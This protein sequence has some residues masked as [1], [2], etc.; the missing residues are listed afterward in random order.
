MD[1][2]MVLAPTYILD[3]Q[4]KRAKH[5]IIIGAGGNGGYF[6]PQLIRQI[7]LQNRMLKLENKALHAVTIIDADSVEDKNLTRQNFLPRDVGHNK[8][9]VMAMRY[10]AAFGVEVTY[11]PE[12]LDGPEML[13]NIVNQDNLIPVVVGAVDNNKTRAI[14]YEVFK[15]TRNIFWLDMGNEEW[16][17]QVVLG[18]NHGKDFDK[19]NKEPHL[20]N[21]PCVADIYPEI[22]E[23]T[24]KLPHEMSCAERAVS[25]PQN[26]FTNQTAA[27]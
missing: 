20:F 5:W 8:A 23:A 24:D 12:Y 4:A 22:L 26:I 15:G 11:I 3:V 21:I 1:L 19:G 25:N 7:S 10:G 9:E 2:S 18:F 6:I 16:A 27:I 13:K 17:G 14:V